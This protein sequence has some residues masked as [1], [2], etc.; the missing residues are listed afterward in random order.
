MEANQPILEILSRFSTEK[1]V[2]NAQLSLAWMLHKYPNAVPIPG[3][4]NKERIIENL[5]AWNVQLSDEEFRQ[6]QS[7]LD[8]CK[9]YGHRGCTETEQSCFGKHW[10]DKQE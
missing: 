2:T 5:G 4:K 6:L 8:A 3:S 1:H 9:V 7:A 10:T